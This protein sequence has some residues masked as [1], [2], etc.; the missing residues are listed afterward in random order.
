MV[1]QL[2][3]RRIDKAGKLDL[4][5]RPEALRGQTDRQPGDDPF[6]QRRIEDA[7]RTE[8]LEEPLGG[9][10]HTA[11]G[12]DVLANDE[13]GGILGHRAGKRQI[14]GLD[15][16]NFRH[17]RPHLLAISRAA[18]RWSARSFGRLS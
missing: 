2:V 15:E 9:S 13:N 17:G 3:D 4:R 6:R 18:R 10:K 16:C 1:H 14:Y 5:H 7:I 11:F 12:A 8:A